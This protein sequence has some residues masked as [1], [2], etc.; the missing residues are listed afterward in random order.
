M[1][2]YK[3]NSRKEKKVKTRRWRGVL[4]NSTAADSLKWFVSTTSTLTCDEEKEEE[5]RKDV[6]AE[7][8]IHGQRCKTYQ[9]PG[10]LHCRRCFCRHYLRQDF[11]DGSHPAG[12]R[13]LLGS[14]ETI[15]RKLANRQTYL[16]PKLRKWTPRGVITDTLFPGHKWGVNESEDPTETQV[17]TYPGFPL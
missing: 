7:N 4:R 3:G 2:T 10:R 14:L 5:K 6:R 1:W 13:F 8:H 9:L 16:V 11:H 17:C 12:T 15:D